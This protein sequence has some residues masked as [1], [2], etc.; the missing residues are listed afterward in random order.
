MDVTAS[1][2][3][4]DLTART[5]KDVQKM[6]TTNLKQTM[7]EV[8]VSA[9]LISEWKTENAFQTVAILKDLPQE[10]DVTASMDMPD[11]MAK[12]AKSAQKMDIMNQKPDMEEETVYVISDSKWSTENAFQREVTNTNHAMKNLNM[13]PMSLN[14]SHTSLNTN[15]MN[16][17]TSHMNHMHL[18]NQHMN[19]TNQVMNHPSLNMDHMNQITILDMPLDI[20]FE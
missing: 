5:A 6:V 16:Q 11:L 14:T 3:M 18:M 12:T 13:N 7:E 15:P 4:P 17:N 10:E 19:H 1:M 2:D 20:D 9:T 8:H